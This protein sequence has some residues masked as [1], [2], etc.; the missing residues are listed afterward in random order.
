MQVIVAR[1]EQLQ[2]HLG[3]KNKDTFRLCGVSSHQRYRS[4][5]FRWVRR[6]YEVDINEAE[7]NV[8]SCT[9]Q[10]KILHTFTHRPSSAFSLIIYDNRFSFPTRLLNLV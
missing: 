3:K 8:E 2:V 9:A 1:E 6:D 10:L 5:L 4:F 7:I